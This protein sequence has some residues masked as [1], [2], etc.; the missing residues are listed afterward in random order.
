MAHIYVKGSN[1][2]AR[3]I[4]MV[5]FLS[6]VFFPFPNKTA[7]KSLYPF[8]VFFENK[9]FAFYYRVIGIASSVSISSLLHKS[10]GFGQIFLYEN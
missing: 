1:Q 8:C 10:M 9:D 3:S 5:G 6:K 4:F 2:L 7:E